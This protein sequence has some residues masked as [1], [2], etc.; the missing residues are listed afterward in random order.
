VEG[1]N[2]EILKQV[3]GKRIP[4]VIKI[5][6]YPKNKVRQKSFIKDKTIQRT[7]FRCIGGI[8]LNGSLTLVKDAG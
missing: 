2:L 7:I 4:K 5:L 6:S 3:A 8:E 1:Y